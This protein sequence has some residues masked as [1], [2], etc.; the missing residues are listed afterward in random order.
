[1]SR[2][3]LIEAPFGDGMHRFRLALGQLEELQ[4]KTDC[5][6]EEL[7]HRIALGTWKVQD[8]IQ[9]IRLGLMGGGM[10]A[11][12]SLALVSR[13]VDS[14]SLVSV[15]PLVQSILGAALLGAPDEDEHVGE[16]P[17]EKTPHFPAAKSASGTYTKRAGS[18]GGRRKKSETPP[19]GS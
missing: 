18:S 9:T 6:P 11:M 5:G 10:D 13:Y 1:M 4:E 7:Y 8:L 2:N 17:A 19:S 3:A 16:D 14:G 12:T 15:K